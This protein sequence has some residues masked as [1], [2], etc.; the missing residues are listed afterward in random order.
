MMMI[1][2][3]YKREWK[4]NEN[5][6]WETKLNDKYKLPWSDDMKKKWMKSGKT[7]SKLSQIKK[8]SYV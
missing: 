7:I 1:L 4:L 8:L 5:R 3:Q 6:H 2:M